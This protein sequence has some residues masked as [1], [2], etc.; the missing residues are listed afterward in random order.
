MSSPRESEE[1]DFRG[2]FCAEARKK[3]F[4]NCGESTEHTDFIKRAHLG[5]S[6]IV[7]Q[8]ELK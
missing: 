8:D 2:F 6:I 4:S 1:S 3:K 7:L 5:N